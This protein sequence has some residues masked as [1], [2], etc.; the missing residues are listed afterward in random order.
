MQ[1]MASLY[2]SI[3]ARGST[4]WRFCRSGNFVNFIKITATDCAITGFGAAV[5]GS[6]QSGAGKIFPV[7][8]KEWKFVADKIYSMQNMGIKGEG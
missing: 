6:G 3:L 2:S 7:H 8:Y 4:F 1:P 5:A